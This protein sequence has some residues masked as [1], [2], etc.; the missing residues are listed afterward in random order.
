MPF[1]PISA[2][3][4]FVR[5]SFIFMVVILA[6]GI[7][8]LNY[9][10][11]SAAGGPDLIVEEISIFPVEPAA[12]DIVSITVRVKNQGTQTALSNYVVCY[13]DTTIINTQPVS[14]LEPGMMMTA[15]FMWTAQT[16][17]H[18][19]RA[20]ADS[21]E[22]INETDETNNT[23]TFTLTPL[24]PDLVIES[25]NWS[26]PSP[27]EGDA[28]VFTVTVG[29]RGNGRSN[30]TTINFYIDG[31]SRGV[32]DIPGL[33]PGTTVENT[34]TWVSQS[35][36]HPLKAD[37][38]EDGRNSETDESNNETTVTYSTQA[39][40]LYIET[41]FHEPAVISL[42]DAV[43]ITV[44][45]TNQ[46]AGRA[47]S[48]YLGYRINGD[49]RPLITIPDINA[50]ASYNAT[51][52]WLAT[53]GTSELTASIDYHNTLVE[54]DETNNDYE[55]NL[56]TLKPDIIVTGIAWTPE[57]AAAG[58]TVTISFTIKNRGEG[59]AGPSRVSCII[60][61][62][63]QETVNVPGITAGEE[64]TG[65]VEWEASSGTYKISVAAD[66]GYQVNETFEDNNN[67]YSYINVLPPDLIVD[68]ISW[69]PE[70]PAHGD[71][72]SFNVT[73]LNQGPGSAGSFHVG[74]YIDDELLFN[75]LVI[76]LE[77]EQ[78]VSKFFTWRSEQGYHSFKAMVDFKKNIAEG[79][80]L[81]N[82]YSVAVVAHMPDLVIEGVTWSPADIP[83]GQDCAF[84][85]T[86]RNAGTLPA[87]LTRLAYY[88]DGMLAGYVD[89][90]PLAADARA[91]ETLV[92]PATTG[93]HRIDFIADSTNLVEEIDEANNTRIV[94]LPLP[95]LLLQD[96]SWSPEA[97]V[98]GDTVTFSIS[99]VNAGGSDTQAT[100]INCKVD[101]EVIRSLD[102]PAIA[103]GETVTNTF[104]WVATGGV[105]TV[106][107]L[108]DV[109]NITIEA[110]ETN[111]GQTLQL[112]TMTA[113]LKVADITWRMDNPLINNDVE[114]TATITNTGTDTAPASQLTYRLDED[115]PVYED[116]PEIAAGGEYLLVLTVALDP[117]GHTVIMTADAI[118]GIYER[119]ETNNTSTVSFNMKAPDLI[120]RTISW[121]PLE[122][123]P[124]DTV[125]ISVNVENRGTARAVNPD[126]SLS[127]DGIPVQ[128]THIEEIGIGSIVTLEFEWTVEAGIH[129]IN[130]FADYGGVIAE[131]DETNNSKARTIAF[132]DTEPDTA[133][134]VAPSVN[135]PPEKGFLEEN[136]WMILI[137]AG[138]L[139]FGV[140]FS[141]LRSFRK[142]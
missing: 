90:P 103:P 131:T 60:I 104:E 115:E 26:P 102:L 130:V 39:P 117:G 138:L 4:L 36:Q 127:I 33:N 16:G 140:F 12:G 113:E 25:I 54:S 122:A 24:A 27:S 18:V 64:A 141:L 128:D 66:S 106:D 125:T 30:P 84:D 132:D 13:V 73:M 61:P 119:D 52:G 97:A 136:W 43:D 37:V 79:N 85:I 88:V 10:P 35:G 62:G 17:T 55:F 71:T 114:L 126:I 74:Y 9:K 32:R 48:C 92:W 96:I 63:F 15:A 53:S 14:Q 137:V 124:G 8:S 105:H 2:N 68:S 142:D 19:I 6:A 28:V 86:I 123:A 20:T 51:M 40:D 118:D 98:I 46:G 101:G 57:E 65:S 80:E 139:G 133:A 44:T 34:Y 69:T 41:I 108:A 87:P 76:P 83:P 82:E 42:N 11:A 67:F 29:N 70:H 120:V 31:G 100:V 81:N 5:L 134:D 21:S 59:D 7:S 135:A 72:V 45:V 109:A 38:D 129:E 99:L 111:N 77:S 75:S 91:T 47:N 112:T 121:T 78:S 110:D 89:M 23:T 107:V 1:I 95:D 94:S 22:T 116:I 93:F 49:L 56:E 50:G 3:K 58:D